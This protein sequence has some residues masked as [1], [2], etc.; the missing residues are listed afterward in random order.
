MFRR[1][2]TCER[3]LAL[4]FEDLHWADDLTIDLIAFLMDGLAQRSMLL[5]CVYRPEREYGVSRLAA[6]AERKVP[7]LLQRDTPA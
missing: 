5:L 7:R 1:P 2:G 6:V 3:P 4:V